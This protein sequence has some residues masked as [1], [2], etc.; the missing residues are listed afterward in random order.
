MK[1]AIIKENIDKSGIYMWTNL[2]RSDIYIGQSAV[3][4]I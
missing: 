2:L 3:Q 4:K 1:K